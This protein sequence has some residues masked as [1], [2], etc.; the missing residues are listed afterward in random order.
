MPLPKAATPKPSHETLLANVRNALVVMS[1][2]HAMDKGY[3]DNDPFL[4]K[5]ETKNFP[6]PGDAHPNS[7]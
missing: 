7:G 5:C 4:A 3:L 1:I 6:L 2:G